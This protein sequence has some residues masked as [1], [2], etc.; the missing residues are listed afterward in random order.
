MTGVDVLLTQHAATSRGTQSHL[1]YRQTP[2]SV[3]TLSLVCSLREQN[4]TINFSNQ[5]AMILPFCSTI[6]VS[7]QCTRVDTLIIVDWV[8]VA[9]HG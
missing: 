7:E 5:I 2:P 8:E 1:L 4:N 9:S 6:F 3:S